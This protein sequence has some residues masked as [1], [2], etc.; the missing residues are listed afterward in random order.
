MPTLN[1]VVPKPE[2]RVAILVDNSSSM[3]RLSDFVVDSFNE[4]IDELSKVV[5][6][7]ISVSLVFFDSDV[8]IRM[9]NVPLKE[10]PRLTLEDYRPCGM[11]AL[12]DATGI[13]I[14]KFKTLPDWKD[15]NLAHLIV[16]ISDGNGNIN[17]EYN[18]ANVANMI[19]AL[20]GDDGWTFTYLGANVDVEKIAK[21]YNLDIGN[22]MSYKV[23][24]KNS[25]TR[26][27]RAT[28]AGLSSYFSA[29]GGGLRTMDSFYEP[30]KNGD[31]ME[32]GK[33]L[34][35]NEDGDKKPLTEAQ[36]L[37]NVDI[38][39]GNKSLWDESLK[40]NEEF[41]KENKK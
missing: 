23:D 24:D 1:E 21:D 27:R 36:K 37:D 8:D 7:K 38:H 12:D 29:R 19:K 25:L 20:Q 4:Q 17:K 31:I 39:M 40:A 26:S 22:T 30:G 16:I 14:D 18:K 28:T 10:V 15:E 3:S 32:N 11:T 33:N 6:Q 35:N 13:A 34:E 9:F 2:T 41:A 5:D